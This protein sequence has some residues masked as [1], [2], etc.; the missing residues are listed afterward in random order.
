MKRLMRQR[1]GGKRGGDSNQDAPPLASSPISRARSTGTNFQPPAPLG[2][3]PQQHSPH[4]APTGRLSRGVSAPEG[5]YGAL[6]SGW[7]IRDRSLRNSDPLFISMNA[8]IKNTIYADAPISKKLL[9]G[10]GRRK[11]NDDNSDYTGLAKV[12]GPT[13]VYYFE[14]SLIS[15]NPVHVAEIAI[16]LMSE[17]DTMGAWPGEVPHSIGWGADG[18][19]MNGRLLDSHQRTQLRS[20]D[21]IGCGV[22]LGGMHRVFFT[23]NGSMVVPPTPSTAF[24]GSRD[25]Q[26]YPVASFRHGNGDMLRGNFGRDAMHSFGW[27]GS[28][29]LMISPSQSTTSR[30]HAQ[31]TG[32]S[33]DRL[34]AYTS[35][36]R[37]ASSGSASP[38]YQIPEQ[39]SPLSSGAQGLLTRSM[40]PSMGSPLEFAY[41]STSG[42]MHHSSH[43]APKASSYFGVQNHRRSLVDD[44]PSDAIN[45]GHFDLNPSSPQSSNPAGPPVPGFSPPNPTRIQASPAGTN[46]GSSRRDQ[47]RR[48]RTSR[49]QLGGLTGSQHDPSSSTGGYPSSPNSPL[50][51]EPVQPSVSAASRLPMSLPPPRSAGNFLLQTSRKPPP[52]EQSERTNVN[53]RMPA[54]APAAAVAAVGNEIPIA[55]EHAAALLKASNQSDVD[56][57]TIRE[58]LETC[59][60]D[61]EKLQLMLS[62]ALEHADAIDNL[63][64]LFSVNDGICSAIEAGNEAM[65]RAKVQVKQDRK[66]NSS[67]GPTIGLLAENEDIFSLICMLRAPN[68]KRVE[69]A[70]ALMKFARENAR[71][72]NEIRS[73]GGMHSFLTLVRTKGSSHELKVVASMAVA[74]VLPSFVVSAQTP[75]SVGLKIIECLRFLAVT[76]PLETNEFSISR[77]EMLKA[78]SMGVNVLWINAIQPL[79]LLESTKDQPSHIRPPLRPSAS[80]RMSKTRGRAGASIFDQGQESIEIRELTELAVTLVTHLAKISDSPSEDP[81]DVGFN[82]V[83]QVCEVD[84]ARPI[85]VRE[86]LL[87]T[88]VDWIRSGEID[89][90]RP[91]ASALRY[92][93]SIDDRYMA[94]WIH[95]QV[96]NEG[97]V[98]EIV[99]LLNESVGYD[100]R[101]AVAQMI[102]ALCIAPHTRAAVVEARCVGYLVA[103]LYEHNS[104]SSEDMV[105]Y[106]ASALLQ[107]AAGA[108]VRATALSMNG[109][110]VGTATPDQQETV[111]T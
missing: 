55:K 20:G 57:Q 36:Q 89:K 75:S 44:D 30:P 6:P 2:E 68:D 105:R 32:M 90:I 61:Q 108:M 69:A 92:L 83:E 79:L 40:P 78:A 9:S 81:L 13:H 104:P 7:R 94:G 5:R 38:Y 26:W 37:S 35:A 28:D 58:M 91:A 17:A 16:G 8:S 98:S 59:K 39:D 70:F 82:I 60:A 47:R 19:L 42:G 85:A 15:N 56:H 111:I 33:M 64:E 77:P 67:A 100:V 106:A 43:E 72:R 103:L 97:A 27:S 46:E 88:L 10:P 53:S 65:K 1:N 102:S 49:R 31:T 99:K 4:V 24:S 11:S 87:T 101:V 86:G 76:S 62:N 71:L 48:E 51:S 14:V 22:E 12:E 34:P 107:L 41:P 3:L 52:L 110:T 73:S 29:L 95:S 93:I 21:V 80:L 50:S 66:K 84:M 63:E 25:L 109:V 18:L 54:V 23:W 45:A 96:V 74:Y